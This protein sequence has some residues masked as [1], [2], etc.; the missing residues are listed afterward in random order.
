MGP[1]RLRWSAARSF[2]SFC[3]PSRCIGVLLELYD[4]SLRAA[5]RWGAR[6]GRFHARPR[7]R[8]QRCSSTAALNKLES[9]ASPD[10]IA[11]ALVILV[12]LLPHTS[13]SRHLALS[14]AA[15]ADA[16]PLR[17]R[18]ASCFHPPSLA[19]PRNPA[20]KNTNQNNHNKRCCA[21]SSCS[22]APAT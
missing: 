6:V 12:Q 18:D 21:R 16:S 15:A 17:R 5:A 7:W 2:A 3:S 1:S 11:P 19:C 22:S 9:V 4:G 8:C 20:N 13:R 14:N 10:D